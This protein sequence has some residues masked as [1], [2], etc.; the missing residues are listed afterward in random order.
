MTNPR[1]KG[2]T[3]KAQAPCWPGMASR[4]RALLREDVVVVT[5]L[6]P[7]PTPAR[8]PVAGVVRTA[9]T[10]DHVGTEHVAHRSAE[11]VHQSGERPHDEQGHTCNGVDLEGQRCRGHQLRLGLEVEERAEPHRDVLAVVVTV[12]EHPAPA[13]VA[14]TPSR[15]APVRTGT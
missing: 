4:R 1:I 6:R 3:R 9:V 7:S 10:V 11:R 13:S 14:T 2:I 15:I 5:D 12:T 8:L